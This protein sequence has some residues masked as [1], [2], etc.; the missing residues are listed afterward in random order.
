MG[1]RLGR[2]TLLRAGKK[3]VCIGKN[4]LDHITE[5]AHLNPTVWD[6]ARGQGRP[7]PVWARPWFATP[8]CSS[9]FLFSRT[10]VTK[11]RNNARKTHK[12]K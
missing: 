12:S 1:G 8:R 5:L 11:P 9:S 6:A 7:G 4:Y 10:R 2:S 3:V